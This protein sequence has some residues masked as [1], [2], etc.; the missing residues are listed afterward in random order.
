MDKKAS[1]RLVRAPA[2]LGFISGRQSKPP[3]LEMHPGQTLSQ[4]LRAG[5]NVSQ[6]SSACP[7]AA[8]VTLTSLYILFLHVV[9][10]EFLHD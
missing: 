9:L 6:R 2:T 8:S 5:S 4:G 10:M 7:S 3:G 1:D